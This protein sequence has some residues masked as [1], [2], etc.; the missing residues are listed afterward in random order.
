MSGV[1]VHLRQAR[2]S[3]RWLGPL[4]A[5]AVLLAAC[6]GGASADRATQPD[7]GTVASPTR[8]GPT[9]STGPTG[10][11]G[12]TAPATSATS[13]L[14]AKW[15]WGRI[16]AFAP[17][18]QQLQGTVTF[19]EFAWCDVQPAPG[20]VDWS[21]VD[22]VAEGT[23]RFGITLML[24]IRVG[25]CWVTAGDAQY[26]RGS[27]NK[28]ESAMP[29][30][31]GAYSDFVGSVVERYSPRGVQKYAIEN[32]VN[33]PSYWDGS[34]D[35]YVRL[36]TAAAKAVRAADPAAKVVDA[37]MSSTSYGYAIADQLLRA[38]SVDAAVQAYSA[39]F[40]RRIGTRDRIPAVS[41]AAQLQAVLDSEHGR[42]N[43]AFLA[44]AKLLAERRV[45]DVRQVHFYEPWNNVPR[46]VSFVRSQTPPQVPVEAWEVG[47]FWRDPDATDAERTADMVKTLSL[48]LAGGVR[49]AVWLPLAFD[50]AGRNSDEPRYGLLEAD[51]T[52]RPSGEA[53]LALVAASDG[54]RT[55]PV[56]STALSGVA[57]QSAQGTRAVMWSK[58]RQVS[59]DLP[60]GSE[61]Q[62]LG[63]TGSSAPAGGR[64]S[65]GTTPV[66]LAG[67]GAAADLLGRL[68]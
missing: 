4:L 20:P 27:K 22:R 39:Y 8:P 7:E 58:G 24:K 49:A 46:L 19:Y 31:M 25:R 57:F 42:R 26:T 40:Q 55:L 33:S 36:T 50:P 48:L 9:G 61:L 43:L 64:V 30:D 5:V 32:E 29:T 13:A 63:E 16:E 14:G 35:D 51:G 23:K 45:V 18:L 54:A 10:P 68:P 53:M 15:D 67:S 62:P 28:T 11:T 56:R 37:G 59:V 3:R 60:A 1:A 66:L 6:S 52:I 12:P 21:R 17:Y 38:G 2:R 34:A 44:A 47:S 65:V 41:N